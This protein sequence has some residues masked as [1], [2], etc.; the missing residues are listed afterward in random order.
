[1]GIL[2]VELDTIKWY[3]MG[4]LVLHKNLVDI[5]GIDLM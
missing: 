5:S 4:C 1:M 3:N 2:A